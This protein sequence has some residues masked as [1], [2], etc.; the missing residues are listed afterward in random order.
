M[1]PGTETIIATGSKSTNL[2]KLYF[3]I[4]IVAIVISMTVIKAIGFG[5]VLYSLKAKPPP[6]TGNASA[7]FMKFAEEMIASMGAVS[8]KDIKYSSLT[9]YVT[10][11]PGP[12]LC[13]FA[14]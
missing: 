4:T 5:L 3:I 14:R 1:S 9:S 11:I 10:W 8:L 12:K 6:T 2:C 13:D 7:L